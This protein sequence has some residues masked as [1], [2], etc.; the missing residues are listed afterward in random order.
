MLPAAR[1]QAAAGGPI[2]TFAS[3]IS[4]IESKCHDRTTSNIMIPVEFYEFDI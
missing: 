2:M 3:R 4:G 1:R